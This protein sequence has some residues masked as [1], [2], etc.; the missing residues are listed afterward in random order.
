MLASGPMGRPSSST[1]GLVW[2]TLL[3]AVGCFNGGDDGGCAGSSFNGL[4]GNGDFTYVAA[5][6]GDSAQALVGSNTNYLPPIARGAKFGLAFSGNGA[7][8]VPVSSKLVGRTAGTNFVA[9]RPGNAGFF[10]PRGAEAVDAQRLTFFE[11]TKLVVLDVA[12]DATFGASLVGIDRLELG[13]F[14]DGLH[15]RAA[16]QA[17]TGWLQGV[18]QTLA[19]S[20]P[21][22]WTVAPANIVA[23]E[24]EPDG[25]CRLRALKNGTAT[26]T[27]RFESLSVEVPVV[28]KD[29]TEPRDAGPEA[30][31]AA[32]TDA[33]ADPD[34]GDAGDA[35]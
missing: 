1:N 9:L 24:L 33:G 18:L 2:L 31:D 11:S 26:L 4:A 34:G 27:A 21:I 32:D 5:G 6:A 20:L 17:D 12:R 23:L 14:S 13:P 16:G 30:S 15:L 19:G 35:S 8:P 29:V 7:L 10:V 25:T 28:V 22:A 3:S